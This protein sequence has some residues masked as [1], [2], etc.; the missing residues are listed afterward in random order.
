MEVW[1]HLLPGGSW[2]GEWIAEQPGLKH[3]VMS[4]WCMSVSL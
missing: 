3:S 4:W 1:A 2:S